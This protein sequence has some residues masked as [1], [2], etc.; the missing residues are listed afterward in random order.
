MTME[1]IK[2]DSQ[3]HKTMQKLLADSLTKPS[4]YPHARRS[5]GS[6]GRTQ[7]APCRRG[8]NAWNRRCS[9]ERKQAFR[10]TL[11]SS[12]LI[13]DEQKHHALFAKLNELTRAMVIC[14]LDILLLRM[15]PHSQNDQVGMRDLHFWEREHRLLHSP[16]ILSPS[17][18]ENLS[19]TRRCIISD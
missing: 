7:R 5:C 13:A 17:M 3:K 6:F 2:N 15:S 12:Y 18:G 14:I 16:L 1:M 8:E 19:K 9:A 11:Y 4:A 10:D